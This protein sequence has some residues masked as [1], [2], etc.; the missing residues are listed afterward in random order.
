[1]ERA[2]FDES[3]AWVQ[4]YYGQQQSEEKLAHLWSVFGDT[5]DVVF[6]NAVQRILKTNQ[7]FPTPV[8][9]GNAIIEAREEIQAKQKR[10]ENHNPLAQPKV[11]TQ[12]GRDTFALLRRARLGQPE[13]GL[14]G[15]ELAVE[16]M[17]DLE[18]KYPG[19]GWEDEGRKLLASIEKREKNESYYEK[20]LSDSD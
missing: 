15:K 3:I 10:I 11:R 7:F 2:T 16:M 1:M 12:M 17:T 9:L 8:V 4:K 18:T 19:V 13:R 5:D 14:T 20:K 6:T